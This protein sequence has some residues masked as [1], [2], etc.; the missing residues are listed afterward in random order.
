[1]ILRDRVARLRASLI[2][3]G[4]GNQAPDWAN[5]T[6]TSYP[7]AVGPLSSVEDVVDQQQTTTRLRLILPASADVAAADRIVWAG[8]TYEID[9]EVIAV[10]RRGRTH[11]LEA[12]LI[13]VTQG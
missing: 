6:S 9:G 13:K 4:Y 10:K 8:Q 5:A 3:A 1:V 7:A 12:V 11:H 2:S